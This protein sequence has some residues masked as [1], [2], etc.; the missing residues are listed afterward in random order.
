MGKSS[1]FLLSFLTLFVFSCKEQKTNSSRES[2][3]KLEL[4]DTSLKVSTENYIKAWN[5]KDL[6]LLEAL[7]TQNVTREANGEIASVNLEQLSNTMEF[8]HTAMPDFNIA[9]NQLVVKGNK[10]YASWTSSGTNTGMFGD[11]P[12]T[13]KKST[14]SGFTVLTFN[15]DGLIIHEQAFYD[16]LGVMNSWGYSVI[17]PIME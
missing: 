17:P 11:L 7:T 16:L 1:L 4:T 14:T 6:D 2:A 13:G 9:S 5:N 3:D 10:T 12:P 15:D 8:W